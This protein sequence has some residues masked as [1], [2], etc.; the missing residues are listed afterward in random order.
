M[1]KSNFARIMSLAST[2]VLMNIALY[3]DTGTC[4][5]T[6]DWQDVEQYDGSLGVSTSFVESHEKAVGVIR[7]NR[8]K[9]G[10]FDE[11]QCTGTLFGNHYFL[12]AG[13]CIDASRTNPEVFFYYQIDN[14]GNLPDTSVNAIGR[15]DVERVVERQYYR[16][17]GRYIDYAILKLKDNSSQ[18]LSTIPHATLTTKL[19]S[20][21]ERVA[22]IHAPKEDYKKISTGVYKGLI[23]LYNKPNE[24]YV[25]H[26]CDTT[27]GSSG[28]GILNKN[29]EVFGVQVQ[30]GCSS[31]SLGGANKGFGIYEIKSRSNV[32]RAYFAYSSTTPVE[33]RTTEGEERGEVGSDTVK[34]FCPSGYTLLLGLCSIWDEDDSQYDS[35]QSGTQGSNYYSCRN[36][37]SIG[38]DRYTETKVICKD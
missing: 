23:N 24:I 35:S 33:T 34:A 4:G 16:D 21:G 9:Y 30:G 18:P 1:Q 22:V 29:G 27:A 6:I 25:G 11:K 7:Y 20:V 14:N 31:S 19:P 5:G 38:E 36:P 13:H 15:Y 8:D 12:T 2:F 3:A 37:Y 17:N 26:S 10:N 28:S 32:L